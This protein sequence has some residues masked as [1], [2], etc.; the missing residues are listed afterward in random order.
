MQGSSHLPGSV[1]DSEAHL[2]DAFYG[3]PYLSAPPGLSAYSRARSPLP[4]R[5]I[6]GTGVKNDGIQTLRVPE[7]FRVRGV[8]ETHDGGATWWT[9][10]T[11]KAIQVFYLC[12]AEWW[13]FFS[14][15]KLQN[16]WNE[17][18]EMIEHVSLHIDRGTVKNW[19][20]YDMI[21]YIVQVGV[22]LALT[23]DSS[24]QWLRT[25]QFVCKGCSNWVTG[26]T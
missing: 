5:L 11:W 18:S 16:L 8:R 23:D 2:T 9:R 1:G 3:S 14:G 24:L 17:D 19:R 4:G 10:A 15:V 25:T 13:C 12:C 6:A 26:L 22:F 7:S 21:V 20:P